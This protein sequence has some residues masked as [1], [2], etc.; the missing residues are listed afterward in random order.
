MM[1]KSSRSHRAC[2][3]RWNNITSSK[4]GDHNHNITNPLSTI[5][6]RRFLLFCMR[7]SERPAELATVRQVCKTP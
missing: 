2:P 1:R 5:G 7:T 4:V 3:A 6:I